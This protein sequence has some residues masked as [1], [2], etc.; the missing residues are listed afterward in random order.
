M[1][2]SKPSALG[3]SGRGPPSTH[4]ESLGPEGM[5]PRRKQAS[6]SAIDGESRFLDPARFAMSLARLSKMMHLDGAMADAAI[7]KD[8]HVRL[9]QLASVQT[10]SVP[11]VEEAN[12]ALSAASDDLDPPSALTVR[13]ETALDAIRR[14]ADEEEGCVVHYPYTRHS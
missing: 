12:A 11:V 6:T 9:V 5:P 4:A 2:K 1:R 7:W 8:I 3:A 14:D 10:R 13:I